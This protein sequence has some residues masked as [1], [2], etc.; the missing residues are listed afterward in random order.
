MDGGIL[1]AIANPQLA[2]VAGALNYR[3][4]Q[5]DKDEAKRK[6]IT[7]NKLIAQAI[8]SM[9]EDSPVRKLFEDD[10]QAGAL[11]AKTLNIPLND[12]EAFEKFRGQVRQ[13]ASVA[14][15]DPRMAIEHAKQIQAENQRNGVQDQN[16]DRWVSGIDTAMQNNDENGITTQF[17]ALH[18]MDQHLNSDYHSKIAEEKRKASLDERGMQV[19]ERE[20]GAMELKAGKEAAD[21]T[22]AN[23][24]IFNEYKRLLASGDKAGAEALGRANRFLPDW[25]HDAGT[26]NDVTVAKSDAEQRVKK[27]GDIYG[28]INST[29]KMISNYKTAVD[30]LDAGTNTGVIYSRLPSVQENSILFDN[31]QKNIGMNI[32]SSGAFGTGNSITDRDVKN[33]FS[34]A[35]PDNLPPKELKKF[36]QTKI[37]AQENI[38]AAY[39]DAAHQLHSGKS[40]GDLIEMAR[41][42]RESGKTTNNPISDNPAT[43]QPDAKKQSAADRLNAM[44]S[45]N[46]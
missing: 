9:A 45:G 40:M 39:E 1:G 19:K 23:L 29:N 3:Q 12:G 35:V 28:D 26:I 25:G 18:V 34:I 8:P 2:D 44:I 30:L 24:K 22:P 6:E 32:L 7:R 10:P 37:D 42:K 43:T 17:N 21:T 46:R 16:L 36:L 38:R 15:T 11:M 31:I 33:A 14:D 5:M 13:L 4:A 41:Q 27:I 20:A